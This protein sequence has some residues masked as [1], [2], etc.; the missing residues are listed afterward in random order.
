M[1]THSLLGRCNVLNDNGVLSDLLL[2]LNMWVLRD[3]SN[4]GAKCSEKIG[5]S[6]S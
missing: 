4:C 1:E 5:H 6:F 2:L 3:V